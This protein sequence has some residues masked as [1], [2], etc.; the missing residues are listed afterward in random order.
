MRKTFVTTIK[1]GWDAPYLSKYDDEVGVVDFAELDESVEFI[2]FNKKVKNLHLLPQFKSIRFVGIGIVTPELID[3][4]AQLPCLEVLKVSHNKNEDWPAL[5]PLSS[6]KYLILH[7]VKKLSTLNFL[8]N[9]TQLE[10]LFISEVLKL[11]DI[12][13]LETTLNIRE[14]SLE[15][16]LH[17]Q[18]SVLPVTDALFSLKKL[19]YLKFYSKKTIFN[20]ADFANFKNLEYL[21]LSPR[22]YPFEFYAELEKY[23][24]ETCEK[25]H[26]PMFSSYDSDACTKCGSTDCLQALGL[27]Q[28]EFCPNCSKKKLDKLLDIYASLSG[29]DAMTAIEHIPF[30]ESDLEK[31]SNNG[32]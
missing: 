18:S 24:P 32:V 31:E 23:L 1:D 17:G 30:L 28:R 8:K 6:L 13:A 5:K 19:E 21:H 7:N 26:A 14:F 9:M 3:F 25:V 16:S 4:L 20:A 12:S 29:K 27:R 11:T 2:N 10:S 15:G 22:R